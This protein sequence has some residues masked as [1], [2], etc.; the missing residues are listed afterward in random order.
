[1]NLAH[2]TKQAW[3]IIHNPNSYWASTLKGIY[4]PNSNFWVAKDRKGS[5]WVWKS[6]LAGRELLK[7][8]GRWNIGAGSTLSIENDRWLA[9]GEKSTLQQGAPC[10]HPSDLV[11]PDLSWNLQTIQSYL[12][13]ESAIQAMKIVISWSNPND[14]MCWSH[15]PNGNFTVKSGY[16]ALITNRPQM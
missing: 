6:L 5:S 10:R 1:M 4:F 11:S 2:L 15:T 9:S 3:R 8:E 16:Q 14:S 13:P 7:K 12:S